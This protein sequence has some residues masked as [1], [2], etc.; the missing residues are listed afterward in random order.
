MECGREQKMR[1][2]KWFKAALAL[3]LIAV[4]VCGGAMAESKGA[5]VLSASMS[6]YNSMSSRNRLGSLKRGTSVT[7][8]SIS[9]DWAKISYRGKTGYARTKDLV[10][11]K[12]YKAVTTTSSSIKFVTRSSYRKNT[13][14]T[15]TLAAGVTLYLAGVKGSYYLFYDSTGDVM[16]YVKKSAVRRES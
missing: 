9:G 7:V 14:Y 3:V 15:G 16:G 4:L 5:K 12:H 6:V 2:M 8:E 13:Y 10:F 11:N 1:K